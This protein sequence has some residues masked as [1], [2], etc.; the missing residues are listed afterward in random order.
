[1][2]GLSEGQLIV[3]KKTTVSGTTATKSSA[4][5]ATTNTRAGFGGGPG[6][7]GGMIRD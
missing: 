1:L 3:T 5:S 2:S 7:I 6:A 4:S